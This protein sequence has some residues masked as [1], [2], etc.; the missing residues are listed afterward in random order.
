MKN[1]VAF[2]FIFILFPGVSFFCNFTLPM[3]EA[4]SAAFVSSDQFEGFETIK[5]GNDYIIKV[6]DD[7][8]EFYLKNEEF[9]KGFN[10][11][12]QSLD[13]KDFAKKLN[14]QI[15]QTHDVEGM[16]M[17]YG[18]TNMYKNFEM[19]GGKKVNIQIAVKEDETIVGFPLI[20]TGF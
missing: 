16:I 14:A 19:V 11:Y 6:Y 1:M 8:K 15:Y 5:N 4:K 2:L 17:Y 12:F 20:L 9:I 13:N 18:Y 3:G 7:I 10:L